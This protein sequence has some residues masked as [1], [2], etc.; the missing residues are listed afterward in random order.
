M[1]G[2][3]E[4]NVTIRFWIIAGLFAAGGLAVFYGG[5]AAK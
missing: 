1:L 5:F 3:N 4:V 2:W